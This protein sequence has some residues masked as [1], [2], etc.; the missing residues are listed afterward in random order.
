M[1]RLRPIALLFIFASFC[2]GVSPTLAN[3][4][5]PLLALK[6]NPV[7]DVDR[8]S[9]VCTLESVLSSSDKG[10]IDLNTEYYRVIQGND[11]ICSVDGWKVTVSG[12]LGTSTKLKIECQS[13]GETDCPVL[14]MCDDEDESPQDSP[15]EEQ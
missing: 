4:T 14:F 15:Q 6:N 9:N 11:D 2:L 5:P 8:R 12:T 7:A 13:G 10:Y 3:S 1:Y